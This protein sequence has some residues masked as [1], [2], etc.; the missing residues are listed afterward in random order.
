V[1]A[2]ERAVLPTLLLMTFA[3]FQGLAMWTDA[4]GV[5]HVASTTEAPRHARALEGG[6]YSVVDADSRPRVLADGGTREADSA[7]WQG[8]FRVARE[9]VLASRAL[10][11]AAREQLAAAEREVCVTAEV[12]VQVPPT[13]SRHGRVVVPGRTLRERQTR[14]ARGVAASGSREVLAQRT[15]EREQAE[16]ALRR[17][18]QAALAE[19]VPLRDWY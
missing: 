8:R 1:G 17:V 4:S 7:W 2:Y 16:L 6:S 15:S 12:E 19:H 10:E 18:E 9:A 14:C 5:V 13:R 11:Q 3:Q